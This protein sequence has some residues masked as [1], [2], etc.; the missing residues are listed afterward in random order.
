MP[1]AGRRIPLLAA[2]LAFAASRGRGAPTSAEEGGRASDEG[3]PQ[4]AFPAPAPAGGRIVQSLFRFPASRLGPEFDELLRSWH[5]GWLRADEGTLSA[6]SGGAEPRSGLPPIAPDP[7][8]T[9]HALRAVSADAATLFRRQC[10]APAPLTS[11]HLNN[12]YTNFE[13]RRK[14][15]SF[16][17]IE[18]AVEEMRLMHT[19]TKRFYPAFLPMDED[20]SKLTANA[21][22]H[23]K[24][25]KSTVNTIHA[26]TTLPSDHDSPEKLSFQTTSTKIGDVEGILN[27]T[28]QWS[29]YPPGHFSAR[30][31]PRI[32]P[33]RTNLYR[34]MRGKL[35]R[36]LQQLLPEFRFESGR[37][38]GMFWYPPGGVREWHNNH[39]DLV[40]NAKKQGSVPN[41]EQEILASQV[42]RM[43]AVRTVRDQDFDGRLD[44]LRNTE[45]GADRGNDDG[46][47]MHVIPGGDSGITFDVLRKAGAR[48]L[49]EKETMRQW[50]DEFAEDYPLPP[51]RNV[52]DQESTFVDIDDSTFDRDSVWR[53]P[54]R[55]GYVT[56]F[57]LPE[58]WHC[59][60]SE[61]VHRYS[62]GFAFSDRE[63]QA[64]LRLAGEDFDVADCEGNE[65]VTEGETDNKDEL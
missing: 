45:E 41:R 51:G 4:S 40:G 29:W 56:L 35:Q 17:Y 32:V 34:S 8:G 47:A 30:G 2:T 61:E 60:V 22:I 37:M 7:S 6:G 49:T 18:D 63:V 11:S 54:D 53:L 44:Q 25:S 27:E 26:R 52:N 58:L 62:L 39:L 20:G 38:S 23:R 19:M 15:M 12:L 36:R 59:I 9:S 64:L 33:F 24:K 55:D 5:S 10:Y 43:Y 3:P 65:C 14:A 46:S 42:W 1:I 13:Q 57:R 21:R 48:P 31:T 16:E 50:S 28:Q